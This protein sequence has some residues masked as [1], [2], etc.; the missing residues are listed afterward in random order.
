MLVPTRG[1]L[2]QSG[3]GRARRDFWPVDA[4]LQKLV[5]KLLGENAELKRLVAELREE[6]ACLKG[7]KGRPQIKPSG[8]GVLQKH[9][10]RRE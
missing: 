3:C 6:I 1:G 10:E 2:V 9:A 8:M 4:E 7:L 5:V